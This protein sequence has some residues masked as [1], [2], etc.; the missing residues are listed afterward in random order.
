MA[1]PITHQRAGR[2]LPSQFFMT[3]EKRCPDPVKIIKGLPEDCGVIFRDYTSPDRVVR[4]EH[5]ARL[6]RSLG[7]VFMVAA[8]ARLAREVGAD[9]V[10]L[11]E[12][13]LSNRP[14]IYQE[15]PSWLITAAVHNI[16]AIDRANR[17]GVDAVL[18][19]PVYT[20]Q[21]HPE[22]SALGIH[23]LQR[24]AAYANA[25]VYALGGITH[26]AIKR[27]APVP[28]ISGFAGI[29]LFMK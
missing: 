3:E 7:L 2:T 28:S 13:A 26:A 6:C 27:L 11:P 5:L 15:I 10:H 12:W 21:S 23:R 4:A 16:T 9:G 18:L 20:T 25:P 14:K 29:S 8:D 24:L 17:L 19:A 22:R 1:Y